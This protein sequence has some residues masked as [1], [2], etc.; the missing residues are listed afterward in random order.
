M[1]KTGPLP[2]TQ[3]Q[4]SGL[5]EL[6]GAPP[7]VLNFIPD[8]ANG[9]HV[10]PGIEAWDEFPDAIPNASPVISIYPWR[11]YVLYVCEDRTIWVW[12]AD[13]LVQ[14]LSDTSDSTTMLD[15]T[16]KPIWTFDAERVAVTG[17]GAPQ[18]WQGI[19]LSSRL[20]PGAVMPSGAPL[21][22]THIAYSA[23]RFVGNA[24]D[25]SGLLLW[26]DPGP[27]N[28][29][30]WPPS[31]I[32]FAEAESSPDP[33]VAT[34]ATTNEVFAF[35][36]QTT[37]VYVP[38][39]SVAFSITSSIEHGVLAVY[40]IIKTKDGVFAW[41]S[42]SKM[43]VVSSG[44]D[45][46]SIS[47]PQMDATIEGLDV[48]SDCWSANILI[49]PWDLLLWV[50]P[51]EKRGFYFEQGTQKWGEFDTTD[52]RGIS[53]GFMPR[54]HAYWA[55]PGKNIHLVGLQDGRIG[56]LSMQ[57][58]RDDGTQ[59]IAVSRTGFIDRGTFA[60]KAGERVQFQ[61]KRGFTSP[62]TTLPIVEYRY[63][64]DFGP[65][66]QTARISLGESG[67]YATVRD[68]WS[69]GMYRAREHEIR[70]TDAGE[71]ILAGATETFS[72][73]DS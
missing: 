33:L 29:T 64:D 23:Q 53:V 1:S 44:R 68:V 7:L 3:G 21:A 27:G 16:G 52:E 39:P 72:I 59:I 50:F 15:G 20:A 47:T 34:W 57:A 56:V 54:C 46:K 73:G 70:F 8:Q 22:L 61:L 31:G 36:T 41:L 58:L 4:A 12:L 6:S 18:Q 65:F 40:S 60:Y 9:L 5:S 17:G 63:R 2:F 30:S 32:H 19:G 38:D 26:T 37:S 48:T 14:A 66:S 28:H 10:R 67:D 51:T 42:D 55:L 11:Q 43:F 25:N 13:G 45:A 35:G 71:F 49:G 62:G 24:N 69:R